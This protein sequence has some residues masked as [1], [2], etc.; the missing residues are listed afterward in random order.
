MNLRHIKGDL[1]GGVTAGIV[2]L[3]LA[4]AFGVQS[5][6]G[7][8]AGLYGAIILGFVASLLGGTAI[9]VSGPTGPMTVVS[10]LVIATLAS[11]FG[12]LSS[13]L[14]YI[15]FT[16]LLAGFFQILFGVL[17]F[18]QTVRYIPYPVISGFMT[19]IGVI[20]I[21]MQ[22]FP[23]MGHAS[24]SR[25]FDILLI[26]HEPLSNINWYAAGL[27]LGTIAIIYLLPK[28]TK[29]V[30]STLVAFVVLSL[31]SAWLKF[32][33]PVIGDIP[34][35]FPK[36][37]GD[38]LFQIDYASLAFMIVPALTLA[39]LG[40]IDSLLTSVVV[41]N[42]TGTKSKN[43]KE[44]VGQGV[45]NMFVALFAGI[46]GAG[47]TMRTLV[48]LNAGGI[49]NISGMTHSVLLLIVLL[50]AGPYVGEV[51]MAVLAGM[52][53]TVGIG[54]IDYRGLKHLLDVPKTEAFIMIAVILLT[55]FVDLL[56]AVAAGMIL[57]AV[58]FMK[59]MSDLA[60]EKTTVAPLGDFA[61]EFSWEDDNLL[62]EEFAKKVY[63][64]HIDGPL[65]FGFT[66]QFRD[67]VQQIPEVNTVIIRMRKVPYM[68][69]SGLYALED[70]I[71][72]L[73]SKNITVLLAGI[74]SQPLD[75]LKGVKAVP[76]LVS[77]DHLFDCFESC[78]KWLLENKE[79]PSQ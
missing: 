60:E 51:P 72:Y 20:I 27:T 24:P 42:L 28:I 26:L 39:T 50:G 16:F 40:S 43:N 35:G 14:P 46:P 6:M 68:D 31:L 8:A 29:W 17:R 49:T 13:A 65:F 36:F 78:V 23:A 66:S 64:K 76:N 11:K 41:D 61:H 7:A 10:A 12:S 1:F 73:R 22:I 77:E 58:F 74:Q 21:L 44:L 71:H 32:P 5:G 18:G 4:L 62:P 70:T 2:A 54:I 30:P 33:V 37:V 57:A 38:A 9:Q 3:P 34:S 47:A 45:G 69:Q 48:N 67:M 75:M 59:K 56:K 15:L 25:V 63:I 79:K 55:V 52:L 19:G 53:V